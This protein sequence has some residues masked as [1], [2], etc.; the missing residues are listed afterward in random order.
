MNRASLQCL[1]AAS[2]LVWV[3]MYASGGS[4]QTATPPE[5]W[6]SIT[7]PPLPTFHPQQPKRIA[8]PNG[9]VIFLQED[10]ELPFVDGFIEMHGGGRNLPASKAGMIDLYSQAWRTSGTT[11][12]SGDQLDDILEAKAAKVETSGDVDSTSVSWS[13]LSDDFDQVFGIAVDVLEHPKFDKDKLNLAKQQMAAGIVRRNDD[14][15]EIAGREAAKLIYG[16]ASP[17]GRTPELS[18]VMGVTLTDLEDFHKKTVIPNGMIIGISGDFDAAAMEKKLR[19]AFA[20][21]PKGTPLETP[22]EAYA[23][24]KPGVYS[25]T[26]TDVNQSNV[27]VLGLGTERS[28]PDYYALQLMNEVFSGGFGSRLMQIVRT[29][30]GLAYSVGGAYGASYDHPGV[31]YTAASTKSQSTVKTAQALL[32]QINDLKSQPFTET[33]VRRAKDDLLNSFV[34]HYDSKD[35]L[36]SEQA[37]LEFYGYPADFIDKYHDAIEKV[38]PADLERVARK[39]IDPSKM[40]I[41]IVGNTPTFDEPLS[42][43]GV[44]QS[45]DISIPMP[46]GMRGP[47]QQG[48]PPSASTTPA[49]QEP[50]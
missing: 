35:K 48:P 11:T 37:R 26:K 32:Q 42:K 24:P 49:A 2:L 50:R 39:Y 22:K 17:Y 34:F 43:L 31:F 4:A 7:I 3:S 14:A 28:N 45:V 25:I 18:T 41:L 29:R 21:M 36:L 16:A 30:M 10:H 20:S 6:Q 44:V 1:A 23:G 12:K 40:G 5:P 19:T 27:W 9:I 38:T 33:E 47:G 15:E 13:S 8:L 46:P